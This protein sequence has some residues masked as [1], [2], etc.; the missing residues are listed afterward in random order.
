M[1]E[2]EDSLRAVSVGFVQSGRVIPTV[3]GL[4][5]DL[6]RT[7]LSARQATIAQCSDRVQDLPSEVMAS[8]GTIIYHCLSVPRLLRRR[9]TPVSE[10]ERAFVNSAT[11]PKD[12]H[13]KANRFVQAQCNVRQESRR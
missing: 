6:R 3:E 13:G 5:R 10:F 11:S 12:A 9:K 4:V 8:W 2:S 1:E 7:S